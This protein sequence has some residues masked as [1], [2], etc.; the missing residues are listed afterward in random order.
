MKHVRKRPDRLL[1]DYL[2]EEGIYE[3]VTARAIKRVIA[4]QL[5]ALMQAEGLTKSELAKQMQTSRAQLDRL[6]DPE[7]ESSNARGHL[8][9]RR[10]PSGGNYDLNWCER[11]LPWP[12]I[13]SAE[14][15]RARSRP[16]PRCA[17]RSSRFPSRSR[18][19]D[20]AV[21]EL[22]QKFDSWSPPSF[23][24]TPQE[25]ERAIGQV[26]KRD[27][28]DIKLAQAQVRNLR[29]SRRRRCATSRSRPCPA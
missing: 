18:P 21:R 26:G 6:L 15:M 19:G 14:W 5:D 11:R 13:S 7:S 25:I 10:R 1:D 3:E 2:K 28:D 27:L 29:R 12:A 4:R 9:G 23:K 20:A 24:L 17:R 22:S 16:T 8:L